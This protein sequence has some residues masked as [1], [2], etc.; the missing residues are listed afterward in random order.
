MEYKIYKNKYRVYENGD[1]YGSSGKKLSPYKDKKWG[2]NIIC[3][4]YNG[5][6]ML[7]KVHRIV[8]ILFIPNPEN[9]PQVNH[10]NGNKDNN[11]KEN[12]EWVTCSENIKHSYANGLSEKTRESAKI[13]GKINS[14]VI[15]Q[16]GIKYGPKNIKCAINAN[17]KRVLDNS[18]GYI[19]PSAKIASE[20]LGY[21]YSTL[22]SQLNGSKRN[23]TSLIYI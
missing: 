11:C 5:K 10:I 23:K 18:N 21:N 7:E 20:R 2:Y 4:H 1:I 14:N 22:R 17:N 8:A 16:L 19:Y 3:T 15:A 9:K 12:L 6:Q 13:R